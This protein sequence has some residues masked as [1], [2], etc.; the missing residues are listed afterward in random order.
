VTFTQRLVLLGVERLP[1]QVDL[2]ELERERERERGSEGGR[3][4]GRERRRERR[5]KKLEVEADLSVG[6][7]LVQ[8]G[9]REET[10][11]PPRSPQRLTAQTKHVSCQLKPNASRNR[12]PASI[13]KSQPWHLV[14]NIFS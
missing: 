3:E 14:P 13:L 7:V 6:I 10:L 11:T 9:N 4:G 12:S 2:T 8:K 1:L 5:R